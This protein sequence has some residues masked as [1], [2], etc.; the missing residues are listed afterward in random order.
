MNRD[1]RLAMPFC[2]REYTEDWNV[3]LRGNVRAAREDSDESKPGKEDENNSDGHR[4]DITMIGGDANVER[5]SVGSHESKTTLRF[6]YEKNSG[7]DRIIEYP[8]F[9]INSAV[10]YCHFRSRV[11]PQMRLSFMYD[12][13]TSF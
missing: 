13:Y 3:S 5:D 7:N 12:V 11:I 2:I 8:K 1:Y 10:R 4:Y 9:R 6:S